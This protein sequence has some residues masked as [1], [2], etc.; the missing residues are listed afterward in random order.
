MEEQDR[1]TAKELV[2]DYTAFGRQTQGLPL[3]S[4]LPESEFQYCALPPLPRTYPQIQAPYYLRT[5]SLG[6]HQT[7]CVTLGKLTN[8][9]GPPF[10]Y[11]N[12]NT[13]LE[14]LM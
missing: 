11:Q 14:E 5:Q 7:S 13:Y 6:A 3:G 9:S 8:L 4:L 12:V 2:Q 10:L 1:D